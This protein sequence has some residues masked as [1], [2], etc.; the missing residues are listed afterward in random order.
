MKSTFTTLIFII[1]TYTSNAQPLIRYDHYYKLKIQEPSDLCF[2]A[3]EQSLFIV[4][5]SDG[6]YETDLKG[7]IKDSYLTR[8][9][10]LEAV[11]LSGDSSLIAVDE[12]S[13]KLLY[14]S[15]NPLTLQKSKET[16]IISKPNSGIEAIC[17]IENG[18]WIVFQ[19]K[20][21]AKA[22]VIDAEAHILKS[23]VLNQISDISGAIHY[24]GHLWLLSDEDASIY[25]VS[26]DFKTIKKAFRLPFSG[27]EGI[28][29]SSEG[30]LYIVSDS[31]HMLYIF[32]DFLK[33]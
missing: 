17:S 20:K 18:R 15:I 29:V 4:S 21:P 9:F 33:K 32:E 2:S 24:D 10:D 3:D 11:C 7:N 12:S 6:I 14:F 13:N 5:D 23:V 25:K 30:D 31:T 27:A 1:S 8:K 22:F 16:Q 26:L 28:A 19:E